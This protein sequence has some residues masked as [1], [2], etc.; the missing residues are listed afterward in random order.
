MSL[1]LFAEDS[2]LLIIDYQERLCAAMPAEVVEAH[3][4]NVARLA[5]AAAALSV[6]VIVTEQYPRGLGETIA[7]VRDALPPETPRYAKTQFSA[8]RDPAIHAAIEASKRRQVVVVGMESH[9]CVY[10][11]ARDLVGSGHA[12]QVPQDA[13]VSRTRANW[14]A[15][16]RLLR[17]VGATI[18]VTEAVLFDWI[19]EG[20]GEAFKAISRLVK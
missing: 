12:V 9:I 20:R 15:G 11:T 1:E 14:K 2:L 6:P 3:A 4:A 17:A 13:I 16:Q 5:Q 7:A 18:T 10:Q 8:W 19:K